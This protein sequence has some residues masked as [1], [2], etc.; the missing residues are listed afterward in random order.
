MNTFRVMNTWERQ[1]PMAEA[2]G[3]AMRACWMKWGVHHC[4]CSP[5]MS[6]YE[7]AGATTPSRCESSCEK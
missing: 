3:S 1:Q 4:T 2:Y 7:L 6:P 5:S